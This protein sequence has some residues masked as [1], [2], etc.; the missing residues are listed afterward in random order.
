[1]AAWRRAHGGGARIDL[2]ADDAL[3]HS[4]DEGREYGRLLAARQLTVAPVAD[5]EILARARDRARH[6]IS[7]DHFVEYRRQHPWIEASPGRFHCWRVERG[8]VGITESGI[9]P[10]S[11]QDVSRAVEFKELRQHRLDPRNPRYNAILGSRWQCRDK[12]CPESAHWQGHLLVLPMVTS[13]GEP[14]CP[15][16]G[17]PLASLGAR[18]RLSEIV[19]EDSASG[20]EIMRFP[21]ELGSPVIVGRGMSLKGVNLQVYGDPA[22]RSAVERV[23]RRHLMLRAEEPRAGTQRR[24]VATDLGSSNGTRVRRAAGT[25]LS[26]AKAIPANTETLVMEGD[27]LVLGDAITVRL[28]GKKYL[29]G[30]FPRPSFTPRPAAD[31][32][33]TVYRTLWLGCGLRRLMSPTARRT[34][35]RGGGGR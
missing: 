16:C 1:M 18:E 11:A 3:V 19:V 17:G 35:Q 8:Q 32:V 34:G 7:R 10:R 23:S 20:Q 13:G 12:L 30:G 9:T 33:T 14:R 24:L 2:V 25:G 31:G 15:T 28:S 27:Q 21:L 5:V 26:K 6:V 22:F 29:T 4:L